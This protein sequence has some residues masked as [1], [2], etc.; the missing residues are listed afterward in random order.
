MNNLADQNEL[1]DTKEKL[2]EQ[3]WNELTKTGDP[4]I[5]DSEEFEKYEYVGAAPHSWKAYKE[6][7]FQKQDY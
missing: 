7:W 1:K 4:R 2:W 3:L 5:M 6:G